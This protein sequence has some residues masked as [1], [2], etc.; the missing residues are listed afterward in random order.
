MYIFYIELHKLS[1]IETFLYKR[2]VK[3]ER[4]RSERISNF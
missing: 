3:D 1:T 2:K 4:N